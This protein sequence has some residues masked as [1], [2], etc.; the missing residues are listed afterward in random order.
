M[1]KYNYIT[2]KVS[3]ESRAVI[4]EVMNNSVWRYVDIKD[5]IALAWPRCPKCNAPLVNKFASAN[6]VCAKC[7]TEYK[8][9]NV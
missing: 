4:D 9:E 8:L 1:R 2:L 3:S 5:V 7:R 6:L